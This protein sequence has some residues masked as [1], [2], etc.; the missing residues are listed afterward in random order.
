MNELGKIL[1][2]AGLLVATIGVIL[3]TGFGRNWLGQLPGDIH[4]AKGNWS[5]HFPIIT[6]L[7]ISVVLT[8]LLWVFR[9]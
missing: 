9:R 3:W 2:V 7:L 5:I 8:I 4:L 6:C 1:V